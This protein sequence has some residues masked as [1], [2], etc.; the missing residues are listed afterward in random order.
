MHEE[1]RICFCYS[2][3]LFPACVRARGKGCC[4][5]ELEWYDED[6]LARAVKPEECGGENYPL[7]L[8]KEE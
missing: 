3:K 4:C 5:A 2:C 8:P 6:T 1:G 7:F